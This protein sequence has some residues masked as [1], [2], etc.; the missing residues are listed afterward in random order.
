MHRTQPP[1]SEPTSSPEPTFS[2]DG[3]GIAAARFAPPSPVLGPTPAPPLYHRFVVKL[4]RSVRFFVNPPEL[5]APAPGLNTFAGHPAPRGLARFYELDVTCIGEVDPTTGYFLN[6]KIIDNAVRTHA[7]PL[8][9]AACDHRP[10]ADPADLMPELLSA[11][12]NALHGVVHSIRWRLSPFY[13]VEITSA[14]ASPTRNEPAAMNTS[15]TPSGLGHSART[16]SRDSSHEASTYVLLRQQFDFAASHRLHSPH[17][18][19]EANRRMF[20]KCNNPNGHGHNYRVEPCVRLRVLPASEKSRQFTLADLELLTSRVIIN[21]FDHMYLNLDTAEFRDP[22]ADSAGGLTP[23]VENIAEVCYRLLSA[24]VARHN[25]D[26][27]LA[28]ITV[29]ETDKTS[30]TYPA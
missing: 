12:N 24:E 20:G 25:K 21:R 6:I 7:V 1:A 18:D 8:I 28:H 26:A 22:S 4:Q 19:D 29:W 30:A 5:R 14:S 15:S 16:G 9:E 3:T 27:E 17:L 11:V 10:G 13:S 2:P 23:S